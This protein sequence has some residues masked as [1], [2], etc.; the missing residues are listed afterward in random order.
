MAQNDDGG[1]PRVPQRRPG[2][3]RERTSALKSIGRWLI[4]H[5]GLIGKILE[6]GSWVWDHTDEIQS[7]RD[8]PKTLRELQDAAIG[9]PKKGYQNHHI[10][11]QEAARRDGYSEQ[12]INGPDNVV[13][14]PTL[15]HYEISGWYG[16]RNEDYGWKSPREYLRGK[17]W[18]ERERMGR[19]ALIKSG[20]LKP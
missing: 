7:Y 2:S 15:R 19:E 11:E 14:V 13:R 5:G 8:E 17:P 6:A 4:K 18:S 1:L 10:V 20:V 12:Q 3:S 16:R 9:P